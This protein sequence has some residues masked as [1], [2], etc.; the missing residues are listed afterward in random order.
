MK[1][2]THENETAYGVCVQCG[3]GVCKICAPKKTEG[4]LFCKDHSPDSLR[5]YKLEESK[6]LALME[7]SKHE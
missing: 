2:Y 1:C 4:K 7:Q 5:K 3:Q 6:R